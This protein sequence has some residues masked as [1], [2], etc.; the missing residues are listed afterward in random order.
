MKKSISNFLTGILVNAYMAFT[1]VAIIF[2][3]RK[4]KKTKHQ[5]SA[6]LRNTQPSISEA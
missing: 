6:P 3:R 2:E 5:P 4:R 1:V